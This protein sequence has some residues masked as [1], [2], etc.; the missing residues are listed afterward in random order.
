MLRIGLEGQ[1][2]GRETSCEPE[3]QQ[4]G[5]DTHS[6][7]IGEKFLSNVWMQRKHRVT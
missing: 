5:H 1:E 4:V 2:Q 3:A 6:G 7:I